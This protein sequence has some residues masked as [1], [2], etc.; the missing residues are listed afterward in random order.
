MAEFQ[1]FSP[2]Q[3]LH[4]N[5]KPQYLQGLII[6]HLKLRYHFSLNRT[7]ESVTQHNPWHF[8]SQLYI[9]HLVTGANIV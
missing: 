7:T 3:M 9:A 2:L 4:L 1:T 5:L 6:Q 8:Y